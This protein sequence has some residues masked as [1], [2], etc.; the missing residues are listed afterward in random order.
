MLPIRFS[1]RPVTFPWMTAGLV[2]SN[3][4]IFGMQPVSKTGANAIAQSAHFRH[5]F[6]VSLL[7]IG[8]LNVEILTARAEL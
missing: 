8:V 1:E 7:V 5:S 6:M 2:L 3:V 4:V